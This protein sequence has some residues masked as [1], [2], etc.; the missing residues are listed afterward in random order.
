MTPANSA[1]AAITEAWILEWLAL[2]PK[3]AEGEK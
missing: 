2:Q 3:L 1:A